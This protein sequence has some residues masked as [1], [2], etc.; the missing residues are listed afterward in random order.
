MSSKSNNPQDKEE[1]IMKLEEKVLE[2]KKENRALKL[3]LNESGGAR[4]KEECDKKETEIILLQMEIEE[5]EQ[6]IAE[7]LGKVQELIE[8]NQ[9]IEK[10]CNADMDAKQHEHDQ[11]MARHTNEMDELRIELERKTNELRTA[12]QEKSKNGN[13]SNA[14]NG[15]MIRSIMNQ[16]YTKLFQ[17]IEGKSS[18][19]SADFLKLTAEIIRKETKAALSTS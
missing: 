19:S 8:Q 15:E 7:L 14:N 12:Q 6:K 5:K 2:L 3:Q 13:E 11:L 1:E 4:S 17:S 16:F 9:A 18:L 10:K